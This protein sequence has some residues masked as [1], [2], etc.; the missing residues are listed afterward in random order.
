VTIDEQKKI[1][2]SWLSL[3]KGLIFK[4]IRAYGRTPMDREDLFQEITFQVWRSI[5]SFRGESA[6]TTWIYRIALNVSIR[7]LR[8]EKR[9]VQSESIEDVQ[10]IIQET[11][12]YIDDERLEWLYQEIHKL[13][14]IDRS[15]TLLMLDGLSYKEMSSIIGITETHIGVKINRIKKQLISKSKKLES[16][17]I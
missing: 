11:K 16:Y 17:G 3:H 7:W 12:D 1:F 8:K 6:V 15:I 4:I 2:E 13:D 10:H 14:E 5:L 9:Q